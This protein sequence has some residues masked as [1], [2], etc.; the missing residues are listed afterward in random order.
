MEVATLPQSFLD[1]QSS[2][3]A[4]PTAQTMDAAMDI[5]MEIDFGPLPEPEVIETVSSDRHP[6]RFS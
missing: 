5:D 6:P 4:N 3:S 1:L 2:T